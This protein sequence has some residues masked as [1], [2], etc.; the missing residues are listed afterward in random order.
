MAER[1]SCSPVRAGS[2]P[3]RELFS[4]IS[5]F[6]VMH[7]MGLEPA[8]T[9]PLVDVAPSAEVRKVIDQLSGAMRAFRS[10]APTH[11]AILERLLDPSETRR[12]HFG[13]GGGWAT[14]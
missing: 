12:P 13:T 5:W 2:C 14:R 11:D 7:G 10:A 6:Y 8:A 9:D 1:S 3:Q 4:D